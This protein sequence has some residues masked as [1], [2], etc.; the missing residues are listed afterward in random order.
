MPSARFVDF[1]DKLRSDV[2]RHII[3]IADN[4]SYHTAQPL[5]DTVSKPWRSC[6]AQVHNRTISQ[7]T[8]LN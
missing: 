5:T 2:G 4:A 7:H 3:V 6:G 1:I 8:R